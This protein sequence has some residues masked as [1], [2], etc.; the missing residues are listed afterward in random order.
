MRHVTSVLILS[1]TALLCV[2]YVYAQDL[3][4]YRTFSLGTSLI[5]LSKQ[6]DRRPAD[7][8]VI[9]QSPATIQVLEWHPPLE[10][11]AVDT[12]V[13]S[14]Y[15]TT[16][17]KIVA[18][19]NTSSTEG[20]TS[21]DMVRAISTTYGVATIPAVD[22]RSPDTLSYRAANRPIAH[23]EDAQYSVTLSRGSF[24]TAFELV[25]YS[26]QLNDQADASVA[27]AAKAEQADAPQK[28]LARLK[29]AADD[30]ETTRQSNIKAF[31]P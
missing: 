11:D 21:D 20:L 29:K 24:F 22:T 1:V 7:A 9:Q 25:M 23:W 13:F 10:S 4:K 5:Q 19:Y 6:I 18:T 26:K 2:P 28:E 8:D 14:F 3:S 31:R 27:D 12:V 15:N 30:L 17:Y 16:L